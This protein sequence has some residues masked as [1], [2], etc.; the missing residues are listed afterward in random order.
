MKTIELSKF[1]EDIITQIFSS[2]PY[3]D[4]AI[5]NDPEQRHFF[6]DHSRILDVGS[7]DTVIRRGEYD[8]WVY[9][10]LKGQLL[11]Y[12]E[13]HDK[14]KHLVTH[15]APGEIFGEMAIIRDFDRNATIV[16]DDNCKRILVLGTDFSRFGK[17]DDFSAVSLGTKIT[18][19]RM[20]T[21][22]IRKRLEI[23]KI[24]YPDNELA[25]KV[26]TV[27]PFMGPKNTLHELLYLYDQAKEFAKLLCKWNRSL[28]ID[29][30]YKTCKKEISL[31]IVNHIMT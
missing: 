13:F 11:V 21:Q 17:I 4:Q 9:F 18:F 29:S 30:N 27:R 31:D 12:P 8:Q 24:E 22:V 3:I 25:V 2:V 14:R 5:E 6:V 28:E 15:I 1:S 16:S 20:A 26:Y 23:L 19:Y 10:L 7:G